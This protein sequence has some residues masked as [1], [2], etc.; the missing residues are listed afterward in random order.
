[1]ATADRTTH[2]E[3]RLE[4]LL[5]HDHPRAVRLAIA[6]WVLA[7]GLFVGMAIPPAR[8]LIESFDRAI[9]DLTFPIKWAP[10]TVLAYALDFLGSVWFIWPLRVVVA[11]FF[12]RR[13]QWRALATW[14]LAIALSDPFIGILKLAYGRAR[15]PDGLVEEITGSFPSGHSIAGSVVA[16]TLVV[17]L[18]RAG[19]AR[20]NLEIAAAIFAFLMGGSR[21]YLGA[22]WL[23]DVVSGVAFGAA[24]AVGSAALVQWFAD[25]RLEIVSSPPRPGQ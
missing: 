4:H 16:V 15:P 10:I 6:L 17:C 5:L 14:L 25:W 18:F 20:R 1:M 7:L 12:M 9:Y 19:P 13:N 23:T 24:V 8:D 22:H 11:V 3:G 2:G 21:M